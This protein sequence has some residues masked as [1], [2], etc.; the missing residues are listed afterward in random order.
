MVSGATVNGKQ[1]GRLRPQEAMQQFP[2]LARAL[3][4]F[5]ALPMNLDQKFGDSAEVSDQES[6]A[7]P[8]HDEA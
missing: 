1:L 3:E 6:A 2:L 7:E 5:G 4:V 8:D